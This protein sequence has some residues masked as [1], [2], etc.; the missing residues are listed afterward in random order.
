M[1]TRACVCIHDVDGP[2]PC[3]LCIAI[4][5]EI[6]R[7]ENPPLR[8]KSSRGVIHLQKIQSKNSGQWGLYGI[9]FQTKDTIDGCNGWMDGWLVSWLAGQLASWLVSQLVSQLVGQLVSQ[10]VSLLVSQLVR[11]IGHLTQWLKSLNS[12]RLAQNNQGAQPQRGAGSF[13]ALRMQLA[14]CGTPHDSSTNWQRNHLKNDDLDLGRCSPSVY[15][16]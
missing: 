8:V 13:P 4:V 2:Q 12:K 11:C 9:T 7:V 16:Y 10:S 14:M 6:S 3:V 1:Q 15:Q 5:A